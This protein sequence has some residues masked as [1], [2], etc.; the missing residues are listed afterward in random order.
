MNYRIPIQVLVY[1]VRYAD[2]KWEILLLRRL[3]SRGGFWQGVTGALEEGEETIECAKRE[4]LEETGYIPQY[5]FQIDYS[6]HIPVDDS[7]MNVYPPGTK[8]V[9]EYVFVAKLDQPEDPTIDRN[10]HTIWR[11]CSYEEAMDLLFWETNKEA[12]KHVHSFLLD[13]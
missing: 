7:E 8:S 10:E 13:K 2:E 3:E 11:W 1:P 6:Y 9:L 4:L 5:L 12:L